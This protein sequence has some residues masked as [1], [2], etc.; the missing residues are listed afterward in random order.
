MSVYKSL[1]LWYNIFINLQSKGKYSMRK[2]TDSQIKKSI[3][4]V[5][6]TLA[7]EGLS[8]SNDTIESGKRFLKGEISSNEAISS[9]TRRILV[10]RDKLQSV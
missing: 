9:I 5:K 3:S 6:A 2:M 4:N 1:K 8:P 7:I 10:K